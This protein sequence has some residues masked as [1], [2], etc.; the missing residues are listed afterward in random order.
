M[1]LALLLEMS[2]A[3]FVDLLKTLNFGLEQGAV[4]LREGPGFRQLV[5]LDSEAAGFD[6]A[7]WATIRPVVSE[8]APMVFFAFE[9]ASD[10][11]IRDWFAETDEGDEQIAESA[12][13]AAVQRVALIRE[14]M[15]TARAVWKERSESF[16]PSLSSVRY[17]VG[18]GTANGTRTVLL[19]IVG[20]RPSTQERY[21]DRLSS[22]TLELLP[23]DVAYVSR[24]LEKI[25][26]ELEAS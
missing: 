3:E 5:V 11:V 7:S 12:L 9:D 17:R 22:I 6:E 24:L 14:H 25:K 2:E 1:S 18:P 4:L 20:L 21:T 10:D 19:E 23:P 26:I 13:E 15:P 16:L 8:L